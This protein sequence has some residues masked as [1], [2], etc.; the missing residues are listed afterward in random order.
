MIPTEVAEIATLICDFWRD[1][2][3]DDP[4]FKDVLNAAW[5]VYNAGFRK[6]L[7]TPS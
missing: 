2:D 5:R 3:D 4:V 1:L 6:S 7:V